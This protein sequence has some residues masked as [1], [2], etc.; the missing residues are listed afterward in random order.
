MLCA[1]LFACESND[2]NHKIQN[3]LTDQVWVIHD[4][5]MPKISEI[6]RIQRQLRKLTKGQELAPDDPV[7]DMLTRLEDA[8][9]GMMVWM[10]EFKKPSEMR[11]EKSHDE[12]MTYLREEMSKVE[13]VKTDMLSSIKD[14]QAMVDSFTKAE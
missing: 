2:P 4:E 5:V 9:E 8:D 13:K 6:N 10:K 1:L 12:I 3:E 7:L 11:G 14:G